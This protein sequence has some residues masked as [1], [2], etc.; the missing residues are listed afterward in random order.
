MVPNLT[1]VTTEQS[2]GYSFYNF[3]YVNMPLFFN[4]EKSVY[5]SNSVSLSTL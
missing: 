5:A 3:S 4:S 2:Y 1:M